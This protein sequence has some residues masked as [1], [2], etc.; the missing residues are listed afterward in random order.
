MNGDKPPQ[1]PILIVIGYWEGDR[2]MCREMVDLMVDLQKKHAGN[3]CKV[4]LVCRQDSKIDKEIF[5]KLQ[6]RFNTEAMV[7]TSPLRGYPSGSNGVFGTTAIHISNRGERF[8]PWFW[9]EPDCVP[10]RPNWWVDLQDAWVSRGPGV[11][12]MGWKG[13]CNGDGTGWHITG[14]ALYDQQIARIIPCLTMCDAIP[15]DYHCRARM[16]EVGQETNQIHLCWRARDANSGLLV[17][18]WAVAHGYKDGSLRDVVRK[19]YLPA[20]QD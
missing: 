11:K 15:W 20:S 13:D 8:D 10:M 2:E 3:G 9:M 4:W 18:P 7:G 1:A 16:L 6:S 12:V 19:K 17:Q 5:R 14:C